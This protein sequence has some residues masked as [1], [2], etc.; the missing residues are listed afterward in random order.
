MIG[1]QADLTDIDKLH[2]LKSALTGEAGNKVKI[3][4][5]EGVNYKKAWELLER[6]YEVKRILITRHLSALINLP[7]VE[8]ENSDGLTK[9]ADDTQQHVASLVTLGVSIGQEM[10]LHILET[11]LPRSTLDKWEASLT[12]DAFPRLDEMYEF[13]YKTA[14]CASR[15]ARSRG[16][17]PE[18]K[19]NE[20]PYKKKKFN[21]PNRAFIVKAAQNCIVCKSKQHPLYACNSFKLLSVPQRIEAVKNAKLCY[22]CLRSHRGTPCKYSSCT[23]CQKRHNTLLHLDKRTNSQDAPHNVSQPK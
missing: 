18:S 11:K 17:E 7:T 12:R 20:P 4:A 6:S 21:P 1:S 16:P 9:L 19:R 22:N 8:K 10:I 13:L 3:F 23:T 2:Y 15:R 5:I 14:V